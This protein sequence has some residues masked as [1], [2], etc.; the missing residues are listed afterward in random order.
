MI[1]PLDVFVLKGNEPR[2]LGCAETL[3][4]ALDIARR[5]G[6]GS[7]FVFSHQTGNRTL[8]QIN[9]DGEVKPMSFFNTRCDNQYEN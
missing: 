8:Y 9:G 1:P 5:E 2:W 3:A 7:Y 6:T 4:Q